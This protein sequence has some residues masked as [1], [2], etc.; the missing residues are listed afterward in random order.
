[1]GFLE[2]LEIEKEYLE[3]QDREQAD[4][5]YFKEKMELAGFPN[6]EE[7]YKEKQKYLFENSNLEVL[8]TTLDNL[9]TDTKKVI[10]ENRQVWFNI[11][12]DRNWCFVGAEADYNKEFCE[13]NNISI[14]ELGH[15]G[16]IIATT[17]K[18]FNLV[19]IMK[20]HG[21]LKYIQENI[22]KCF[23]NLGVETTIDGND[24]LIKGNKISGCAETDLGEYI[25]Y[26]FQISFDVDINLIQN[27]CN[28]HMVKVPKG[29]NDFYSITREDLIKELEKWLQ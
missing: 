9:K 14:L 12:T 5:F 27:V 10:S 21:L 7:F 26:Y 16:G 24:L 11:K 2:A 25:I 4:K 19:I 28:K 15:N 8:E 1:M 22:Q 20:E 23:S 13:Q 3:I 18:D 6:L 17:P 29:V